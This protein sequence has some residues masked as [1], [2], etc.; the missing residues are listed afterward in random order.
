[1]EKQ[2]YRKKK[3]IVNERFKFFLNEVALGFFLIFILIIIFTL[4]LSLILNQASILYSI[5]FYLMRVFAVLIGVP[6]ILI[7]STKVFSSSQKGK[8]LQDAYIS[9]AKGHLLLYRITKKNFKFQLLYGILIFLL[10]LVPLNCLF[11]IFIPG[12][13]EYKAYSS[14]FKSTGYYLIENNYFLFLLST[15]VIQACIAITEETISK[16]LMTKRGSDYYNKRSAV[17]ITSLFLGFSEL[18]FFFEFIHVYYPPWFPFVWFVKSFIVGIILSLF[19]L[20]KNWLLPVIIANLFN[21]LVLSH[22]IWSY[23]HGVPIFLLSFLIYTPL[24]IMGGI[25]IMWNYTKIKKTVQVGIKELKMYLKNNK[26]IKETTGDKYFRILTDVII[27]GLFFVMS[28]L[29]AI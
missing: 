3:F 25:I 8:K 18:I 13:V 19:V 5:S 9:P 24:I 17:I 4:I 2:R 21:N 1:M 29:I 15:I 20:R 28:I 14:G 27:G 23:L 26:D 22:V 7:F 16:G 6:L 11:L 12:M 10:V